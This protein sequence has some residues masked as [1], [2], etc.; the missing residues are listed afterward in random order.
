MV[1][2][3]RRPTAAA[4]AAAAV[5]AL[6]LVAAPAWAQTPG[7]LAVCLDTPATTK[8][9]RGGD[10]YVSWPTAEWTD[11]RVACCND[12]TCAG[13][14]YNDDGGATR[15]SCFLK[16]AIDATA[17]HVNGSRC[18][19][20]HTGLPSVSPSPL[21]AKCGGVAY[22]DFQRTRAGVPFVR[23][24]AGSYLHCQAACCGDARCRGWVF[25][26]GSIGAGEPACALIEAPGADYALASA[27]SG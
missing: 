25:T 4:V 18:A 23:I 2:A 9:D 7:P 20:L 21:P 15:P 17:Q 8:C 14:T 22:V 27:I 3:R 6:A 12:P 1:P 10:A 26:P 5:V 19:V 11:C 16:A 24:E 13:F